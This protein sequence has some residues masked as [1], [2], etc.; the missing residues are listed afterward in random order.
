MPDRLDRA[1]SGYQEIM[2]VSA[3]WSFTFGRNVTGGAS[4]GAIVVNHTKRV[5]EAYR[6]CK[7]ASETRK[8]S[9]APGVLSWP[10]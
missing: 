7:R 3:Q 9:T 8:N 10:A 1:R 2:E 6:R 5:S 4:A